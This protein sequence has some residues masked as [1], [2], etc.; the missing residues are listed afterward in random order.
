MKKKKKDKIRDKQ[1]TGIK[2]LRKLR[3]TTKR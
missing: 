2:P 3:G 1:Q